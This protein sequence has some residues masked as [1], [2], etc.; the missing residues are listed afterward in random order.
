[1]KKIFYAFVALVGCVLLT[2]CKSSD[3]L[4]VQSP[5]KTDD[6]FVTSTVDEAF[7]TLSWCYA[8]Y[9]GTVAGGGNY[10]WNDPCSDVEYYPEYNSGNCRPAGVLDPSNT[11]ADARK[12]QFDKMYAILARAARI[13]SIIEQKP[14]Y[15]D[16]VNANKKNDW[17]QLYGE[18]VTMYAY[19]YYELIRHF[20]DI[21]FGI[22]NS[23]VEEGYPLT[24]R[25][26][27][28]DTCIEKLKAVEP[29][30]YDLGENGITA[31][32]M[33]R[34][35]A[36]QMIAECALLSGGYQTIRKDVQGL[37]GDVK[38][39]DKYTSD[40]ASYSRRT[41]WKLYY[42]EA[43]TYFRKVLGE[44]KGSMSLITVDER[45]YANNPYQ[46]G[47]QYLHDME[48]SPE[49]IF[50]FGNIAPNQTERPYS[51]GRPSDGGNSNGAPC[52]VFSGIRVM[53]TFYY[54]GFEDGDKRW[55]ASAVVTG[56]DGQG[57][58]KLV[59]FLAGSRNK[60]GIAINK[61]DI[62]K[63]KV[64]YT[65][66]P[67]NSGLNYVMRRMSNT[68]LLLAEV[69]AQLGGSDSEAIGLLNQLR[70]RAFGDDA[71]N[72]SGLTGAALVEAVTDEVKREL[73]GEGDVRWNEIRNGSFPEKAKQVRAD[74]KT[75][76]EGLEADGYYTFDN[77]RQMSN[78]IWTKYVKLENP[79]TYDRVEGDPVLSPGWR[80]VYDYST[81]SVAGV[82]TGT[83]H[84][85]AIEGLF[86]YIDPASDKAK[87]LEADGYKKTNWGVDMIEGKDQ[88]WDYNILSGIEA[89]MVPYYFQPIPLETLLQSK[90]NVTNGYGLPQK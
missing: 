42:T 37:Y 62:N 65:T 6:I 41:D 59:N 64:P 13:A 52:K 26:D 56:S 28:L 25:F 11:K 5:D 61:W 68:M 2:Q 47:F 23:I 85:L 75:L 45:G 66:K 43:Q 34:T 86:E 32:R 30:M 29:L 33:S 17:T 55:D 14:E 50:E 18:A 36:N 87:A 71:H 40:I 38:F 53:P 8:S 78:Y 72:L 19:C 82:V 21:P 54:A 76:I 73:L 15:Q 83:D 88:L 49:S 20:G 35:F 7:K 44:R 1:M 3:F 9:R 84:N 77:G 39:E 60:G 90:G 70:A 81:T 67:R 74:I 4:G 27:I 89:S 22:E 10:N 12:S 79:L 80:G 48:V 69:D 31:E 58:E 51:Q 16:A 63:M 46:R 24:S 57:N